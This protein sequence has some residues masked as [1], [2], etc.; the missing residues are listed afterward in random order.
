MN[1]PHSPSTLQMDSGPLLHLPP[2]C[3]LIELFRDI[4]YTP[5]EAY[6]IHLAADIQVF[7]PRKDEPWDS[8]PASKLCI[9]NCT[10]VFLSLNSANSHLVAFVPERKGAPATI[11]ILPL[12]TLSTG[13][14]TTQKTFFKSDQVTV[15]TELMS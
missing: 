15:S 1:S 11:H 14:H 10:S 9:K 2:L 7:N 12:L 8:T 5:N 4:Q 13:N 6:T 3:N